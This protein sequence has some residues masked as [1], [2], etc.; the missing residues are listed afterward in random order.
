MATKEERD[1]AMKAFKK[2]LKLYQADAAGSS[3]PA[4]HLSRER[5]TITAINPPD[6]FPAEV[7]EELVEKG[8]LKKVGRNMY[9]IA[10]HS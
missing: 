8:K 10:R 6:T 9:E 5:A 4:S 7:W 2:R 1:K 3:A